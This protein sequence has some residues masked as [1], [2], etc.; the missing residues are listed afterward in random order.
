[1]Y[2]W[3]NIFKPGAYQPHAP[4]SHAWFLELFLCG[5]LYACLCVCISTPK[6]AN[7]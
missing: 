6:A 2:S 7:N 3:Q 1:M 4:A 5:R